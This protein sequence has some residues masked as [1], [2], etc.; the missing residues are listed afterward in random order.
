MLPFLGVFD[1][2]SFHVE[3]STVTLAGQVYRPSLK[4]SA[5]R[6]VAG[7]EGIETVI[8]EIEVADDTTLTDQ[9][10]DTWIAAKLKGR[11][12]LDKNVSSINYSVEVV[13]QSIF[14]IGI[15]QDQTELDRVIAHTKD[16]SYVRRVV[17]YVRVKEEAA[18]G[19]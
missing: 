2:I 16:V 14:L 3:G 5:D 18:Q 10:R 19:S 15:A 11:L 6:V 17:S 1:N 9:A 7:I 12:L 8:N 13:N 4:K